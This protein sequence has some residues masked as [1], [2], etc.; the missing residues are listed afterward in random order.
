AGDLA[1]PGGQPQLARGGDLDVHRLPVEDDRRVGHRCEGGGGVHPAR[2]GEDAVVREV[3]DEGRAPVLARRG[4]GGGGLRGGGRVRGVGGGRGRRR[5]ARGQGQGGE[6]PGGPDQ[7]CLH[8]ADRT[9]AATR[10]CVAVGY[11]T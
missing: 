5:G 3:R 6:R 9:P 2:A 11:S 10:P 7:G 1:G 4:G 8:A